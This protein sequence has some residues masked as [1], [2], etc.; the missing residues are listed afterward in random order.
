[1]VKYEIVQIVQW[2][3]MTH[4]VKILP[5]IGQKLVKAKKKPKKLCS[6]GL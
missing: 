4:M 5:R 6:R 1:M 2:L 3:E